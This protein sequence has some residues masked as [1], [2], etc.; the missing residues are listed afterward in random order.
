MRRKHSH[1]DPDPAF[2]P[3]AIIGDPSTANLLAAR[4]RAED[5]DVWLRGE[6]SGPYPVGVG[7]LAEVQIFVDA[8]RLADARQV[9]DE[10]MRD[11]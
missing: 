9:Y 6:T 2:E 7:G 5:I 4:L 1:E 11:N 3:L 10:F 8:V